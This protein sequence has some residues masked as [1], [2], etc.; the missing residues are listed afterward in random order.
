MRAKER[1]TD[2]EALSPF[3]LYLED[4]QELA[5][6]VAEVSDTLSFETDSYDGVDGVAELATLRPKG[7]KA[8]AIKGT[9]EGADTIVIRIRPDGA[10]VWSPNDSAE[11]VGAIQ[12]AKSVI[13]NRM[14][15]FSFGVL[16]PFYTGAILVAIPFVLEWLN[17]PPLSLVTVIMVMAA[18]VIS[19]LGLGSRRNRFSTIVLAHSWE[20]QDFWARY[21]LPLLIAVVAGVA[22]AAIWAFIVG[23]PPFGHSQ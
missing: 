5:D 7:I 10:S 15:N 23:A 21:G 22:G 20:T 6:V 14:N 2:W 12:K 4:I 3:T 11:M 1:N 9:R 19:G 16:Y 18:V 8:L 17:T 13:W